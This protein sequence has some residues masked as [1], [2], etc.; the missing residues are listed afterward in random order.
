[1]EWWE[2]M[3][4]LQKIFVCI[5]IPSTLL[6][7]IQ[8]ILTIIGIDGGGEADVDGADVDLDGTEGA[9]VDFS[10]VDAGLRLFTVRGFI[11]FLAVMGWMGYT[12]LEAELSV[13]LA[14]VLSLASG[15]LMMLLVALIFRF[16]ERLQTSGNIDIRRAV[17]SSGSVYLKIPAHRQGC[18][19]VNL[20]VQGRY[21]EYD[22]VTDEEEAIP[23]GS[24]IVVIALSG[25]DTVVVKRK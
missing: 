23:S 25:L 6:L 20:V 15:F 3:T 11:A 17:G 19:K 21:G 16:F 14:C 13:W 5:A 4:L 18:G 10:D 9:D 8:T 22:A 1:M 7:V 2:A 24:E 12:L